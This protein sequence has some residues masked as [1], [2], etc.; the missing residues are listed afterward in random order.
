MGLRGNEAA[1]EAARRAARGP[2]VTRSVPPSLRQIKT[3]ARRHTAH[4]THQQHRELEGIK[5]QA[6]WY[7]AATEYQALDATHHQ[8]RADGVLLQRL[9]LGYCT[10]EE[11]A[12]DFDGRE[13]DHCGTR[14]RRPLVHYLLSCPATARLRPVPAAAAHTPG[15]GLL[16]RREARAALTIRHTPTPVLLEVL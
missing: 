7:A 13:C 15:G 6:A 2:T 4:E 8:P 10:R 5:K 1:D 14:T 9:R 16:R 3:Q 12:D 11:L